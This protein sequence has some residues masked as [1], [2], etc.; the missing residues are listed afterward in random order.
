MPAEIEI[1]VLISLFFNSA[2]VFLIVSSIALNV[3]FLLFIVLFLVYQ[4]GHCRVQVV[5]KL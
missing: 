4:R 1:M 2:L 5:G 3:F